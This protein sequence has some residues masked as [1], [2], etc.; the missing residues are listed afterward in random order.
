MVALADGSDYGGSL[1]NPAGWNN[2]Y[3]FR[4]SYGRVPKAD[5]DVWTPTLGVLG[6]MARSVEDL[7]LLLSVQ[8]GFSESAPLSLPGDGARLSPRPTAA[9]A[10]TAHRLGRRFRRRDSLRSRRDGRRPLGD[11]RVRGSG[12]HRRGGAAGFPFRAAVAR[13]PDATPLAQRRAAAVLR[14][15]RHPRETAADGDLRDRERVEADGL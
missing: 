11:A 5:L 4:P 1:R 3:G 8:A 13:L 14:E 12:R 10:R 6:P 15:P 2:V 7:A 9:G